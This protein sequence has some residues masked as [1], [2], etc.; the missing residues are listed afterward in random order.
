M[1]VELFGDA[2][3]G[4]K[5]MISESGYINT[6]LFVD[7][8]KHFQEHVCASTSNPVSLI[9]DNH[10]SHISLEG[11]EFCRENNIIILTLPPH[12][13]HKLQPLDRIF[14][15]PL[16]NFFSSEINKWR[17]HHPGEAITMM[18]FS[19]LFREAYIRAADVR[20]GEEGFRCTGIMPYNP[21]IF[22]PEDF[23]PTEVTEGRF[24][25]Q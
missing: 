15:S 6:E 8:L 12:S 10:G 2:P 18:D 11:I 9:I 23:A 13:S 21:D 3:A 7:W 17:V 20:K 25:V 16:K 4:T 22:G 14:F 24:L 19:K 5:K 1:K